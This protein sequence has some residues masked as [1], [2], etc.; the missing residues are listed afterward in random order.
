MAPL[1]GVIQ[2]QGDITQISTV[3][4]I[5]HHFEGLQADLVV[6]D[7]APDGELIFSSII[8]LYIETLTLDL[9]LVQSLECMIWTSTSRLSSSL[10]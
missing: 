1:D 4:T 6:C 5:F 3:E 9:L 10:P 2:I 8:I 7:G